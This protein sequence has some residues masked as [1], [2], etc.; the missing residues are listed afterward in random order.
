MHL[1]KVAVGCSK[2]YLVST[3]NVANEI[4]SESGLL[5]TGAKWLQDRV[6]FRKLR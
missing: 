4:Q 2:S 5:D 1:F 3:D 6:S